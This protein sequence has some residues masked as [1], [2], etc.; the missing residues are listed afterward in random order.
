[1]LFTAL[2]NGVGDD[3]GAVIL[4]SGALPSV[5]SG[6]GSDFMNVRRR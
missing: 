6:P 4:P 2:P 3:D 5:I 1:M